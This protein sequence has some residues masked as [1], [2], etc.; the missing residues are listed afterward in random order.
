M[1]GQASQMEDFRLDGLNDLKQEPH[2][3]KRW[4]LPSFGLQ[5]AA[6]GRRRISFFYFRGRSL[7][8]Q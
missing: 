5:I 1:G 3:Q 8:L 7:V 4:L 2:P 6:V